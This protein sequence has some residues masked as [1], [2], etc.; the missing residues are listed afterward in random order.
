M[1][2]TETTKATTM[3]T[4]NVII[5]APVKEKP[6]FSSFSRLA[7]LSSVSCSTTPT[8]RS[9]ASTMTATTRRRTPT[10]ALS[11][12]SSLP[13]LRVRRPHPR[14][15][16]RRPL[17]QECLPIR[18]RLLLPRRLSRASARCLNRTRGRYSPSAAPLPTRRQS[19]CS[20][21]D[22]LPSLHL[23]IRS[24]GSGSSIR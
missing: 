9:P 8:P 23:P 16:L 21:Q 19:S 2:R 10:T 15:R 4:S 24:A 7:R 22:M 20:R 11:R 12:A 3:P 13:S 6:N 14:Q 18:R 17:L 5:S 1:A